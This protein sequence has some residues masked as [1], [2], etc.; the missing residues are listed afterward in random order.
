MKSIVELLRIIRFGQAKLSVAYHL[1]DI[2]RSKRGLAKAFDAYD[3]AKA[4]LDHHDAA[5]PAPEPPLY[6]IR[7]RT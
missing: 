3:A 2:E 6:L 7:G 1:Q 4:A 5:D